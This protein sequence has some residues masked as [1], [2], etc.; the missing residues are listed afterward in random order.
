MTHRFNILIRPSGKDIG[1]Q[2]GGEIGESLMS[3]LPEARVD[4]TV[5]QKL[6]SIVG[7]ENLSTSDTDRY[8]YSRD[9]S[10]VNIMN[11]TEGSVIHSPGVIVWPSDT[12]QVSQICKLAYA[13]SVAMVPYGAGSSVVAG[14]VPFKGGIVVDLKKINQIYDLDET[15]HLVMAG[16]GII[17]EH[18]EREMNRKGFTVGHFPS[19][20]YSS[21]LGG[22]LAARSAGQL[23]SKYGKIEDMVVGLEA[24]L[25]RGDIVNTLLTPRSATGPDWNQVIVGSE[26]TLGFITKATIRIWPAPNSRRFQAV[27]FPDV[28]AGVDAMRV[29]FRHDLRPAAIRLYDEL[30]TALIGKSGKSGTGNSPLDFLPIKEFGSLLRGAIPNAIKKTSRFF[31]RRA[32]LVNRLEKLA[33]N[34]CLMVLVFE[35]DERLVDYE[36]EASS[37]ICENLKGQNRGP[38]LAINWWKNRYHVSYKQS[39]VYYNGAFVDTIEVATTWDKVIRLYEEVR[40]AVSPLAFIMA[41]FSHGYQEGCSIYFTF[42]TAGE[43]PLASERAHRRVWDAAMEATLRV[44]GTI[45]HHHGIGAV[46]ARFMKQ[47]HHQLMGVY[48]ALKDEIDPKGLCNPGKMGL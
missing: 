4:P 27:L 8:T 29:I 5:L 39:K 32:D 35:G 28:N 30:D 18:L 26:G 6:A 42:V 9:M 11:T 40:A 48:R 10:A 20:V 14:T 2:T 38:E 37:T 41:H 23:S 33:K 15:S 17:G 13:N 22:Y 43:S 12:E 7:D 34:E 3:L 46:K 45:S 47:E 25:P 31:A 24:V 1:Q 19:S 16:A 36:Y 44:G 21:T